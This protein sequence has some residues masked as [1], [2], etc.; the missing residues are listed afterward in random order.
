MKL[1]VNVEIDTPTG[2]QL[3]ADGKIE[4]VMQGLLEALKPECSYFYARNGRRAFTIVV[5][6]PDM[7]HLPAVAE[8]FWL[9][10]GANVEAIPVMTRDDL[11]AGLSRLG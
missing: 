7:S 2:N 1:L 4:A 6:I 11:D 5:D 3:I 10:L 9:Q 8:P